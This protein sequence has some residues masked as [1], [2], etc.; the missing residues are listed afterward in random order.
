MPAMPVLPVIQELEP[1]AVNVQHVQPDEDE[2]EDEAESD[3]NEANVG[4]DD[5]EEKVEAPYRHISSRELFL[6]EGQFD[7]DLTRLPVAE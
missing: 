6:P 3:G 2:P 4:M 7:L 5:E 1:G